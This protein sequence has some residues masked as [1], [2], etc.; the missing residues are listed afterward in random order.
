MER[1]GG[2]AV[3]V[4]ARLTPREGRKF[5]FTVG[6]AFLVVSALSLWRGHYYPP[7]V[8]A[9]LGAAFLLAGLLVPGRLSGV[10]R[11]WMAL[12]HAIGRVTSPIVIAALYFLVLTPVGVLLRVT[13]RNPLWHREHGGGFWLPATADGRSDLER[14]F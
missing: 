7:R 13:G 12:G 1:D 4:S 8:L 11:G 2:L 9:G 10:H 3:A 5:A 6:A 14:Q